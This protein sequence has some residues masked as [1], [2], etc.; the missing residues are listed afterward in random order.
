MKYTKKIND[1]ITRNCTFV[2]IIHLQIRNIV[3][4]TLVSAFV[5]LPTN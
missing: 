5:A 3:C 2:H 4:L 1:G